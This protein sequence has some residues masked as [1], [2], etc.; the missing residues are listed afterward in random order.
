M[1]IISSILIIVLFLLITH[2]LI[3]SDAM[4]RG[5]DIPC[6][7]CVINYEIPREVETY[8]H[9]IGRTARGIGKGKAFT[10][11]TKKNKGML[12]EMLKSVENGDK[13]KEFETNMKMIR[14]HTKHMA[15][16]IEMLDEVLNQEVNDELDHNEPIN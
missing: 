16:Y 3:C 8:V 6:L 7:D 1:Y 4:S 13:L 9:R 14:F 5:L 2:S 10:I 15:D 12:E 11:G